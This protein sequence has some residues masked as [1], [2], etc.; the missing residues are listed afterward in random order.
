M[1][2]VVMSTLSSFVRAKH[3]V[4]QSCSNAGGTPVLT[5]SRTQIPELILAMTVRVFLTGS[6]SL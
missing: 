3:P 1:L 6:P 5:F 4:P 2:K